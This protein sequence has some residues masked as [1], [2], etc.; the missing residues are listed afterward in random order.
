MRLPNIALQV[1]EAW[2]FNCNFSSFYLILISLGLIIS[3]AI[4]N[5]LLSTSENYLFQLV[6]LLVLEFLLVPFCIVLIFLLIFTICTFVKSLL[7]FTSLDQCVKAAL[8][9][10]SV[11]SSI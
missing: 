1:T 5:D 4:S 8:K 10:L 7:F 2:F 6:I 11:K 9:S 3:P